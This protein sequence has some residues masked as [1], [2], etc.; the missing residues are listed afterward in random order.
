MSKYYVTTTIPYVNGDLHLGHAQEF[1]EADVLARYH[2]S[3]SDEVLF[4]V[5]TDENGEKNF[6]KAKELGLDTQAYVD[7]MLNNVLSVHR[8]YG[9]SANRMIRTT[10]EAH[11]KRVQIIWA[12]LKPYIYKAKYVGYYC[13]GCEEFKTDT[14]VKDTNGVC[15]DH[16]RKYEMLD[17]ENY[18]FKLS[19][20]G[21][22][23]K[24]AIESGEMR[25]VPDSKKNEIL[26]LISSGLEDFSVSRPKEKLAW[27]VE[28]PDD[29]K[30]TIYIWFEAVM[31]YITLLGYPEHKDFEKFWP[32]DVQILGK[33]VLRFHAAVW[34]AVLLA[35]KLKLPK[36]L[37]VHGYI[38][39][40]GKKMSKSLG[41]SVDPIY[42]T[43]LFGQDAA[44]YFLLAKIPSYSDG[45][46]TWLKM[47][48]VYNNDLVNG[49]GN[50]IQRTAKMVEQ[51]LGGSLAEG[52]PAARH[53]HN[54]YH[55]ALRDYRFD[56]ALE[57]VFS[58]VDGI[59]KYLEQT[60][61][62]ILAKEEKNLEHV[63]EIL[64]ACV[65]DLREIAELLAPFMPQT[66]ELIVKIFGSDLLVKFEGPIFP[67][68]E[69]P[70]ELTAQVVG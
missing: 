17:E 23:I 37:F 64:L 51:Y 36:E 67:R 41:N 70:G 18:F 59:N 45:D 33:G 11:R 58:V 66:S 13:V 49:L 14:W 43:Q 8:A 29:P 28:V 3:L 57:W 12:Q 31:N 34:P 9:I 24:D 21:N 53:D 61:P 25:V 63:R 22:S 32:A 10:D 48:N 30:H 69:L 26:S 1:C 54:A 42:L 20:F 27:G 7:S 47:L 44:R 50:V 55:E 35:L 68:V 38:T 5:G 2:K 40:N 62:W 56:K 46:F 4:S 60:Q 39:V 16:N 52:V 65:A 15:P 6:E 19:E